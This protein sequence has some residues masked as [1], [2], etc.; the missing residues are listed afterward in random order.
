MAT[1]DDLPPHEWTTV[2]VRRD[3]LRRL[4]RAK[5]EGESYNDLL[6]RL[7]AHGDHYAEA[8]P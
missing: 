2:S 1:S 8:K 7:E 6:R 3:V 4:R 5:R